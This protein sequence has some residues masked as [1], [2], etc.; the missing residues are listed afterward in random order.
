MKDYS[1]TELPHLK[2]D[3]AK[4]NYAWEGDYAP[5]YLLPHLN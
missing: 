4:P 5:P 3:L 2:T 1:L